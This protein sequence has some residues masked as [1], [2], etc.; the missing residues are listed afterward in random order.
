MKIYFKATKSVGKG[1]R[2]GA[3]RQKYQTRNYN[4]IVQGFYPSFHRLKKDEKLEIFLFHL[5]FVR[6]PSYTRL[7]TAYAMQ[8]HIQIQMHVISSRVFH[9]RTNGKKAFSLGR[10]FLMQLLK[11]W[12]VN[13]FCIYGFYF[14]YISIQFFGLV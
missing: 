10:Y 14:F 8:Y 4:V 12:M 3:N 2:I 9:P 1:K 7:C 6:F 5:P 13:L 11:C